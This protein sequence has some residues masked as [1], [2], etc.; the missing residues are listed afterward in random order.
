MQETQVRNDSESTVL[1]GDAESVQVSRR[2]KNLVFAAAALLLMGLLTW[3]VWSWLWGEWMGN[4]YYSHGILVLPAALYLIW[5][6]TRN[7]RMAPALQINDP[8][9]LSLLIV[10]LALYVYWLN[11]KTYYLATFVMIG[12]IVALIWSVGGVRL[13]RMLAF[14]VSYMVLMVPLPFIERITYPLALFTGVCSGALVKFLGLEINIVGNAIQLPNTNLL[15]G[16]QCSGINSMIA[17]IGLLS[18]CAYILQGPWWGRTL[19]VLLAIP[20][21]MLGNILRVANLLYVARYW[22][23]DAAF[24]FYHDYS[25]LVFFL[26]ILLLIVPITRLL[27][28]RTLRLE[29]L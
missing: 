8:R 19:R 6:R 2:G 14:P 10:T 23:A 22:G 18:L 21:A 13:L 25:G 9:G 3:P 7:E 27:Q 15:I 17:L 20:L 16:A 12:M 26:V 29:V 5:R 4:N 1:A 11:Q 24:R 28:C